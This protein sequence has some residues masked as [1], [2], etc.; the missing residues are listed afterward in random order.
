[1]KQKYRNHTSVFKAEVAI[2][3]A[4]EEKTTA[5]LVQE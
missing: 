2:E 3:A 4:K 5:E 1:M